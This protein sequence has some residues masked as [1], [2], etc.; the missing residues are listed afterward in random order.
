MRFACIAIIN[1]ENLEKKPASGGI[2]AI[3]N[4]IIAKLKEKNGF[5]FAKPDKSLIMTSLFDLLAMI[6]NEIRRKLDNVRE[7]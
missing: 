6:S 4:K 7:M 5:F 2:P 3:E 1:A